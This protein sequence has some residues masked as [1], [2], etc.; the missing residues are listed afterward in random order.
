MPK[1]YFLKRGDKLRGPF[2]GQQVKAAIASKN[3][4]STDQISETRE[5]PWQ[6]I[7]DL[8]ASAKKRSLPT[9]TQF[10]MSKTVFGTLVANYVCPFCKAELRSTE[11]ELD[12]NEACP[13]CNRQFLVSIDALAKLRSERQRVEKAQEQVRRKRQTKKEEKQRKIDWYY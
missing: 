11:K 10:E 12:G 1:Q 2:D 9:V 4:F 5:G 6:S 7:G 3:V 13:E 8:I